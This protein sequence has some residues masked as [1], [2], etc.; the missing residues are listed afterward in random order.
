MSPLILRVI[1]S[2]VALGLLVATTLI[3][4]ELGMIILCSIIVIYA[5][6]E[7]SYL[8]FRK[9]GEQQRLSQVL[10]VVSTSLCFLLFGFL[11]KFASSSAI[12]IL[13]LSLAL[14]LIINSLR[15]KPLS[16]IQL[17]Q[18]IANFV[19]GFVYMGWLPSFIVSIL[20]T[21]HGVAWCYALLFIVFFGDIFAYL[22]GSQL[23]SKLLMPEISPKKS[24]QG[25]LGG[26]FASTLVGIA[27]SFYLI[28]ELSVIESLILG[29]LLGAFGQ[30]GDF[31]E[32]LIKRA[33]HVKDS[34]SIM[35]GHGGVL[36]RIDGVLFAAPV[37]YLFLLL[38]GL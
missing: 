15:S 20:Q 30:M 14:L 18:V 7:S 31:F 24:L 3:F 27:L 25:A 35:P 26:L 8:F 33:A 22:V 36:D 34:G 19:L 12:L 9:M 37:M 6:Y 10:F 16:Y 21:N 28:S 4:E 5:T 17:Y 11:P 32:S 13:L 23:G 29:L 2:L 1:S 38:K